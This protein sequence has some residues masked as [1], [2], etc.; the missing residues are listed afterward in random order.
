M[1]SQNAFS[2][3]LQI[4]SKREGLQL[5]VLFELYPNYLTSCNY[6]Y[7]VIVGNPRYR[8]TLDQKLPVDYFDNPRVVRGGTQLSTNGSQMS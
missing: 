1:Y 7:E 5:P 2:E 4:H 3:L 6:E 8:S